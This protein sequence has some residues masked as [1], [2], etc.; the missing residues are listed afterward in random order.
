MRLFFQFIRSFLAANNILTCVFL[1]FRQK[2]KATAKKAQIAGYLL[3][4]QEKEM[5]A[6]PTSLKRNVRAL[7]ATPK[8]IPPSE[9]DYAC[10]E[11]FPPHP[12]ECNRKRCSRG[13]AGSLRH[14]ATPSGEKREYHFEFSD[15]GYNTGPSSEH[16]GNENGHSYF[17][18]DPK[19]VVDPMGSVRPCNG[20]HTQV[21]NVSRF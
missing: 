5:W 3:A 12:N 14:V 11:D 19:L 16:G 18:L 9:N 6:R 10:V 17:T 4:Q 2:H 8:P 21:Q 15:A 13:S 7:P 1:C 20:I